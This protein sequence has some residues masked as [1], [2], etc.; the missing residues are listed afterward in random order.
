MSKTESRGDTV[1]RPPRV[2]LPLTLDEHH[3]VV[4]M[5]TEEVYDVAAVAA[6]LPWRLEGGAKKKDQV[7]DMPRHE[8]IVRGRGDD[9]DWD[10]L[11]YVVGKH[12]DSYR[13]YF[14]GY[15]SPM[16]YLE[17][18]DG[19]R[20]WVTGVRGILML[21]RCTLDSVEP[22]RRVDQGAKPRYDWDAIVPYFPE[23]YWAR[24]GE[25]PEVAER[26]RK[27]AY[28]LLPHRPAGALHSDGRPR[29]APRETQPR[30]SRRQNDHA[31]RQP[32]LDL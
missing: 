10:V 21:N 7:P 29:E 24:A 27:L 22:P 17:L 28:E 2:K 23:G 31:Q 4:N 9:A 1:A 19:Y 32:T 5:N 18:G 13:A 25:P 26:N 14:R 8:Y 6:R 30:M 11:Y 3:R 12:P 16:R 15:L 20:Y